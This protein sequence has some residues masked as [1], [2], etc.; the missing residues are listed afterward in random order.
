MNFLNILD[1]FKTKEFKT[2]IEQQ[3]E[4]ISELESL[5]TPELLDVIKAKE[6][7]EQTKQAKID[8]E[9]DI[10]S[11]KSALANEESEHLNKISNLNNQISSLDNIINEKKSQ[12]IILDDEILFQ[13]LDLYQPMYEFANSSEY[14]TELE[15]IRQKQKNMIKD[16]TAASYNT[17]WTVNNSASQGK[18][19]VKDNV[20]QILRS[21]NNECE[22]L[23]DKVKYN[24]ID[25]I[26]KRIIK[27]YEDLNKLNKAMSI[28]ISPEYLKLKLQ[29]LHL[30]HEYAI[31][32]QDEKEAE[33]ERKAEM[34]EAAKLERELA[35]ERKKIEKEQKHYQQA[36][37]TILNQ[38]NTASEDDKAELEAKRAELEGHLSD[39]DKNIENLDYR[40]NNQ[41]AGY[42]YVI[43]NIG[44]FGK[45]V[46]K[47]GMTRRLDPMDRVDELGDASVPFNFDVHAMIFSDDAPALEAALH[48]AF[49][50]RKLNMINTR[51]EFFN[52][53][54]DE[55]EEVV[56]A[57]FDKTVDFIK[58]P[59]AEQYR[60]SQL[61][62]NKL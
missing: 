7:L 16:D 51:R 8:L 27:S 22:T 20:K 26:E 47:I 48:R 5:L 56:K 32:K 36:L 19:M 45:D 59:P 38:L 18:K 15:Y 54:L 14:K 30:A 10:E 39:I 4:R 3:Q 41:K 28:E 50:N 23:I 11:R 31:K 46:Y 24:N 52:V 57:N 6:L 35:E 42:V 29:E 62:R 40:E 44:A 21:F 33:K 12:I 58:E 13:E 55:I 53:T 43:S 1:I 49:E 60:E 2:T 9:N 25:S 61:I 17:N 34:R 37:K